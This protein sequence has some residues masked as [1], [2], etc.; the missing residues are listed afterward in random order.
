MSGVAPE[1]MRSVRAE[2]SQPMQSLLAA[3]I[4]LV[5]SSDEDGPSN[6]FLEIMLAIKHPNHPSEAISRAQAVIA[7][8]L[9]AAYAEFA[10]EEKGSLAPGKLADLSVLSQD[11]FRVPSDDLPKTVSVMTMVG[12]KV[13]YTAPGSHLH[14]QT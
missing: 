14:G 5:L 8:T 11:I 9:T 7:Y 6:P 10:E 4:P 2:K 12:G 1:V 3:G 13:I